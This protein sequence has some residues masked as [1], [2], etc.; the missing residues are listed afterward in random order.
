[1]DGHSSHYTLGLLHYAQGHNIIVLGYPPHCTHILQG[2]DMVCFTKMKMEFQKEIEAFEDLHLANVGKKDFAGVFGWAYLRAFTSKTIK[3][4][5][6]ATGLHPF[7]PR[8]I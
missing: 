8:A 5:V 7:H 4:A 2:L 1:M 6:A 3:A